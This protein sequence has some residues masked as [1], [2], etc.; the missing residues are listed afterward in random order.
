MRLHDGLI[1]AGF[2]LAGAAV[3]AATLRFPRLEDGAP[4]PALF[5]QILA[6]LMVLAGIVVILQ[7]RRRSGEGVPAPERVRARSG[8]TNAL[9]VF[10]TIIAFMVVAPVLG[11]LI[12]SA[13]ILFGLMWRL[14]ASVARAALAS[15]GLT[16]FVYVIFGKVLRVPLPLG[17][18]WF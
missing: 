13:A 12:T 5:P 10:A 3:F 6:V 7:G 1:G 2:A 17:L 11:F 9:A 14:G 15:V 8:I 16:L 18:L 4:G